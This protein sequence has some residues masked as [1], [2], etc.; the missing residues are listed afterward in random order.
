M[1][2]QPEH[3]EHMKQAIAKLD[4]SQI[5]LDILNSHAQPK[6]FDKRLR[7]DCFWLAGLSGF[8]CGTLYDYAN[9]SHI[10]TALKSI[11]KELNQ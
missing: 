11:M 9:D 4:I 5:R 2:I 8:A 7:W 10:D 1:K 6:D 3:Y